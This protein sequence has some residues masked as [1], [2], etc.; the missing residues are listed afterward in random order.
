MTHP[1]G[2]APERTPAPAVVRRLLVAIL[3]AGIVAVPALARAYDRLHHPTAEQEHSRFRWANSCE[4]VPQKAT[5][6]VVLASEAVPV[7]QTIGLPAVGWCALPPTE[8]AVRSASPLPSP[9]GLRA[10]PA[11]A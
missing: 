9:H 10:P 3:L 1:G 11:A 5:I 6:L 7:D 2:V 4:W 8:D